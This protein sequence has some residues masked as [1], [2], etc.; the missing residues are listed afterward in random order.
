MIKLFTWKKM[1]KCFTAEKSLHVRDS[2]RV[3]LMQAALS[4]VKQKRNRFALVLMKNERFESIQLCRKLHPSKQ[5]YPLNT[6]RDRQ[7][8]NGH[9][10]AQSDEKENIKKLRKA[11]VTINDP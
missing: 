2:K 1:A 3:Y 6:R 10:S 8:V 11:R 7:E 4:Q 5:R 9:R